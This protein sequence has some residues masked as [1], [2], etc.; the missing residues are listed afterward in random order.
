M[1]DSRALRWGLRILQSVLTDGLSHRYRQELE[2]YL[3]DQLHSDRVKLKICTHGSHWISIPV[4]VDVRM[5]E[6][7]FALFAKVI[8]EKGLRNFNYAIESRNLRIRLLSDKHGPVYRKALA[9][10]DVLSY[11]AKTLTEF[12]AAK[13]CSPKPLRLYQFDSCSLLLLE[14]IEGVPLGEAD[15]KHKDAIRILSIARQLMDNRLVHGDIKL[16]N[17]VRRK[18]G[19]IYLMDCLD[20]TGSLKAALSYDLTNTIYSLSRKLEPITVLKMARLFFTASE[21]AKAIEL[22]DAAGAQ[23]DVLTDE[24]RAHQI[25]LAMELI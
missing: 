18:D 19:S 11:E 15:L 2:G 14:Y 25:R 24:D 8:T 9:L 10:Y 3:R 12:R 20:W 16:D 7:R 17:F 21:I 1:S 5:G 23:I 22:I 4:K 6:T 13:I